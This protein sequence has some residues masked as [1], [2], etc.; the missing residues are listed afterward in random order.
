MRFI[1][2][3]KVF[4]L[5]RRFGLVI[6]LLVCLWMQSV[7]ARAA[8]DI[9]PPNPFWSFEQL[10]E[11]A[12]VATGFPFS[13]LPGLNGADKTKFVKD[14]L[15]NRDELIQLTAFM[16]GQLAIALQFMPAL[17]EDRQRLVGNCKYLQRRFQ[18]LASV[19]DSNGSKAI[20]HAD[21][22]RLFEPAST[23]KN[24]VGDSFWSLFGHK[25]LY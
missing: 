6:T 2:A 22:E 4:S 24:R 18:L 16:E 23:E 8:A 25:Q 19:T 9:P 7:Q 14:Q 15:I 20:S 17:V 1:F 10:F 5:A 13:L 11:Q 21:I 12:N 3:P